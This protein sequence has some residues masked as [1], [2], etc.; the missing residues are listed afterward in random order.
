VRSRSCRRSTSP[1]FRASI[2][3]THTA[4][5]DVSEDSVLFLS[6]LL[7]AERLRRG[8]RTKRRSLG[9]CKQALLMPR[10]FLDDARMPAP[11]GDNRIGP[12]AADD[13]RDEGV[14]V[15]AARRPSR[16]L[17]RCRPRRW[18]GIRM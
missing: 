14:A 13:Y 10:W 6:A 12:T 18:L 2:R 4:V 8:T 17:E 11:A 7:H 1:R 3:I 15:L 16:C 9:T 5:L